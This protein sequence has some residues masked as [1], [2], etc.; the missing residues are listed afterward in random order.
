MVDTSSSSDVSS[1]H[2]DVTVEGSLVDSYDSEV[3][4]AHTSEHNRQR[5]TQACPEKAG[6]KASHESGDRYEQGKS[7]EADFTEIDI[8]AD[9]DKQGPAEPS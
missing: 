9:I 5:Q 3:A 7:M 8:N 1:S 4:A 2:N 6:N